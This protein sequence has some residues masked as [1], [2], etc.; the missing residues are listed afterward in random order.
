MPDPLTRS[1]AFAAC[2]SLASVLPMAHAQSAFDVATIRPSSGEVK[3]E[4]NG[5][6]D[7]AYGTLR[8]HDVTL[9]TC[10]HIAY[11]VPLPLIQTSPNFSPKMTSIHY[12][13]FARAAPETTDQEMRIMLQDLL[14]DRFHLAFHRE[15]REMRVFALT[16]AKGGI[17]MHP[18]AGEGHMLRENNRT[19]LVARFMTMAELAEYL[20]DPLG[21]PLADHTGLTGQYDFVLD[22]TPYVDSERTSEDVRPD[23]AAVFRAALKGDLGLDLVQARDQVS[24]FLID[25]A[26]KPTAN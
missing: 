23:P 1:I 10:I 22:F 6:T 14:R 8:L 13:I 9:A 21:A 11:N 17:K 15:T 12:D 2:L 3:Y 25:H 18:S 20:A 19:G 4:R 7:F 5:T 24:L 16:I 26:D